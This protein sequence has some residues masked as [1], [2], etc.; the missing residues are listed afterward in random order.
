MVDERFDRDAYQRWSQAGQERALSALQRLRNDR[1]RP[2]YCENR[3]CDGKPHEKWK[4]NHARADQ[5]PPTDQGWL[6]WLLMGGRGAGK[7]RTGAE[8]VHRVTKI[9][10]RIALIGPT[11]PDVRDTMLEG[12]S[13]LLTISPPGGRPEYEPSKRRL[14]WPNGAVA[15]TFSAEEPDRLRGPEHYFFWADEPAHWPLVQEC[16]DNLMFGLR[17]G[18][19]PRG[20]VTTTPKPRPWLKDLVA[21]ATTR[22]SRVSTYANLDNLAQPFAEQILKRYEGTRLG[23]QEIHAEILE[24]VEGALWNWDMIERARV[25][26]APDL[27]RIVVGVDPAG[28]KKKSADET[29]IVVVGR[30]GDEFYVLADFSGQ[31]TPHGWATAVMRAHDEWEADSI[32]VEKNYG[33]DMVISNLRSI[34]AYPRIIEAHARRGKALRAEPVVGLYEKDMGHVHHVGSLSGLEDQMVSWQPYEDRDS[35]DRVDAMVYGMTTLMGKGAPASV[36]SP[37]NLRLIQGGAA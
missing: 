24:D 12:E 25:E 17:L 30:A 29:G 3:E 36:S 14:T 37:V 1:W 21:T 11:G 13:G 22:L 18:E 34:D 6:C 10:P 27:D 5:R 31:Y 19:W 9:A 4:W 32:I 16:W 23:R 7:T 35:P 33:G 26:K 15:T 20:V 28:S 8:Y 2:F